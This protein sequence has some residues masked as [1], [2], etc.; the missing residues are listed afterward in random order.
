MYN[1][2]ANISLTASRCSLQV[3]TEILLVVAMGGLHMGRVEVSIL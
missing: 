3:S 1:C 2:P